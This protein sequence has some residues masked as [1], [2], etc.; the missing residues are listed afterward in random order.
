MKLQLH[1]AT[2]KK[3]K[4]ERKE[5][6]MNISPFEIYTNAPLRDRNKGPTMYVTG[7]NKKISTTIRLL[8]LQ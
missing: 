1:P 6:T 4:K 8:G 5:K 7:E 2:R 3:K